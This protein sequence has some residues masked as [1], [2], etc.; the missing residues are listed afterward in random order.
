MRHGTTGAAEFDRLA[1]METDDHVLWPHGTNGHG[2]GRVRLGGRQHLAHRVAL[3]RRTAGPTDKPIACHAPEMGC[4]RACMN[5]RHLYWGSSSDNANDRV[6]EDTHNRG[7]RHPFHKLTESD[8]REI[9]RLRA[10]FTCEQIA[11]RYGV[12][13]SNVQAIAVRRS[14]AWLK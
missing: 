3:L 7:E 6:I 14:W 11:A 1:A 2:Y 4:P 12:S 5:Y 8:V 13:P 10:S 9:R